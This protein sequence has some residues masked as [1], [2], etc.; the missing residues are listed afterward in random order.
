M[1]RTE[2]RKK[3]LYALAVASVAT[4]VHGGGVP[5]YAFSGDNV[6]PSQDTVKDMVT[7]GDKATGE[8]FYGVTGGNVYLDSAAKDLLGEVDAVVNYEGDN[9]IKQIASAVI[10]SKLPEGTADVIGGELSS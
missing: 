5:T 7:D 9:F 1:R 10:K 4:F 2:L 3:V 8:Y 6:L